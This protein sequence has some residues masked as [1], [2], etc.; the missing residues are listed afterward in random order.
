MKRRMIKQMHTTVKRI[1]L[2]IIQPTQQQLIQL[3]SE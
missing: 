2:E 1:L 3:S